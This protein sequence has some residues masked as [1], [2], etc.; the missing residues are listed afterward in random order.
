MSDLQISPIVPPAETTPVP[1]PERVYDDVLRVSAKS[2]TNNLAGAIAQQ[3]RRKGTVELRWIGAAAG[4][5]FLK[6]AAVAQNYLREEG[7]VIYITAPIF[8]M[9]YIEGSEKTAL[10]VTISRFGA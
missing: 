7:V 3:I 10:K 5:Q 4:N 8:D 9:A 6:A 2:Q 1:V